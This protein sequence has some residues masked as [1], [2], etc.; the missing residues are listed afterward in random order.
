VVKAF[1]YI[2]TA[3]LVAGG[4]LFLL[5]RPHGSYDSTEVYLPPAAATVVGPP[6][7]SIPSILLW[8]SGVGLAVGIVLFLIWI[9]Y[10]GK[11]SKPAG[12]PVQFAAEEAV[13][14]ITDGQDFKSAILRCYRQMSLVLKEEQG[15]EFELAMTTREFENLLKKRGLPR[16]PVHEITELFEFVRYGNESASPEEENRAVNCLNNVI[17]FC[18]ETKRRK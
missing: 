9:I 10:W 12:D 6:L 15:I 7:G 8:I 16:E 2:A 14:A 5:L 3:S 13:Q 4:I 11:N 18:R 17:Q 1:A